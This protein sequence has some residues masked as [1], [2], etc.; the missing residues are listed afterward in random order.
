MKKRLRA[1]AK[2]I[3]ADPRKIDLVKSPHIKADYYLPLKPG[4]NVGFI[5]AMSACRRDRRA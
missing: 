3:V 1:G 5:N 2:L 4:S